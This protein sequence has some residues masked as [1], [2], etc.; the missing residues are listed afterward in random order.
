[1][2][3]IYTIPV[4][5][6]FDECR[7]D[8]SLGCPFCR[9]YKKLEN[10]EID[11]ILGAS[12]MEPDVRQKTNEAGFCSE[13]WKKLLL[14]GKRLPLSLIIQSHLGEVDHMM[15]KPGLVPVISGA[16][17]ARQLYDMSCDCYICRRTG[18]YFERMVETAALLWEA[19]D[20]FKEKLGRQPG[21]CIPHFA[22]LVKKAKGGLK[23]KSFSEFYKAIYKKESEYL[24]SVRA[25][26]DAFAKKFDYRYANEKYSGEENAVEKAVELLCGNDSSL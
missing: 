20:S 4:N 21:F 3:Q 22:C 8:S 18:A 15:K 5:E 9:L 19:D 25:D 17:S 6:T 11:L 24:D 1:M 14:A 12:M 2:E 13:H 10:N 26:I 7:N 23:A 16:D